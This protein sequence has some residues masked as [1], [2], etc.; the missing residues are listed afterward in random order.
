MTG[1]EESFEGVEVAVDRNG[2]PELTDE[3]IDLGARV[4][5]AILSWR[6]WSH[7]KVESLDLLSGAKGRRRVSVDCTPSDIGWPLR[8]D[9]DTQEMVVPLTL[10][11]KRT[12]RDLDVSDDAGRSVP[13][14][15]SRSNGLLSAV[16]MAFVV[17]ATLDRDIARTRAH[18]PRV[19]EIATL[20]PPEA[21][22]VVDALLKDVQ[23]DEFIARVFRDFA[24]C[25][26]LTLVLPTQRAASR[27]VL[28]YSYHWEISPIK[29]MFLRVASGF[30]WRP[31][32]VGVELGALYST[33][34]YHFECAVP[35]GLIA[36]KVTL[37]IDRFGVAREVYGDTQV[38][39]ANGQYDFGTDRDERA[40]L[41]FDLDKTLLLPRVLWS[42][43][44]VCTLFTLMLVL[45][46]VYQ[47]LISQ[48]DAATA[49]LLFIPAFIVALNARN[50]ENVIVGGL[51]LPLRIYSVGIALSLFL[52][53]AIIVLDEDA[54]LTRSWWL[55]SAIFAGLGFVATLI[56]WIR[57]C[58]GGR[59]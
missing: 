4:L 15:G 20:P 11:G 21:A 53:G 59:R 16:A 36:S 26:L 55:G 8:A 2:V 42:S 5:D 54:E 35:S 37:P 31:F 3:L 14:L 17:F 23:L 25:F 49:L 44:A 43:L 29:S 12:L 32:E 51:L 19:Y 33:S 10:M 45:P 18:W 34:S 50:P 22:A 9:H 38:A 52:S 41:K 7:R 40:V 39:H 13:I 30:G 6:D 58:V 47:S 48:R 28:K 24:D 27:Q 1:V 56:G 57:L 46:G